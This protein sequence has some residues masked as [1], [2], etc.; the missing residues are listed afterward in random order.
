MTNENQRHVW[1]WADQVSTY[2]FWG[3]VLF[4]LFSTSA[5]IF[6][7]STYFRIFDIMGISAV[8]IGKVY[9]VFSI[10]GLLGIFLGWIIVKFGNVKTMLII[11]AAMQVAG[12][13]LLMIFIGRDQVLQLVGAVLWGLGFSPL[14][15][16]IPSIFAGGKAGM[17]VFAGLYF[18]IVL[19]ER[20]QH[21]TVGFW[22]GLFVNMNMPAPPE[23]QVMY[24]KMIP[25][26]QIVMA[27]IFL[28]PIKSLL[29]EGTPKDRIKPHEAH[30]QDTFVT[31]LLN[32]IPFY[33]LYYMYKIHGDLA[34]FTKSSKI[35]S[36]RGAL[37]LSLLFFVTIPVTLTTFQEAVNDYGRE[38]NIRTHKKWLILLFTCIFY[39]VAA[40]LIQSDLNKIIANRNPA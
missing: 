9:F 40:A 1:T 39:P 34:G 4:S 28:I 13:L 14:C 6:F 22:A 33:A 37:W 8:E 5:F 38:N 3:L 12:S 21:T 29:F 2:T 25:V 23:V 17:S 32:I 27:T 35:L 18:I 24:F 15:I 16:I 19:Y 30:T 36:G 7:N 31:F 11:L 10:A 26:T 20:I